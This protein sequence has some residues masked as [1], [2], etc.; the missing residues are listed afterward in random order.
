M[1]TFNCSE[2]KMMKFGTD[3]RAK[4]LMERIDESEGYTSPMPT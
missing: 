4:A 2:V 3:E 1:S